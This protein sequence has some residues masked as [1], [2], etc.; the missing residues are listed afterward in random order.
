MAFTESKLVPMMQAPSVPPS[1]MSMAD[2]FRM[3]MGFEPSMT[4]PTYRPAIAM[5]RP[6]M[7]ETF[8]GPSPRD[9]GT[10]ECRRSR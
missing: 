4:A 3:A 1:T 5:T 9:R 2:G 7:E 10:G 8:I 6:M